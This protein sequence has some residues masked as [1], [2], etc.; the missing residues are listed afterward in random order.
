MMDFAPFATPD[1]AV[2]ILMRPGGKFVCCQRL[3]IL[4]LYCFQETDYGHTRMQRFVPD[5]NSSTTPFGTIWHI[6]TIG[7]D[8]I[9]HA[10]RLYCSR[11]AS[12][13]IPGCRHSIIAAVCGCDCL[14]EHFG[15][16]VA[17]CVRGNKHLTFWYNLWMLLRTCPG[18]TANASLDRTQ[19]GIKPTNGAEW[20]P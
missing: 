1:W 8:K 3:I 12:T 18:S 5:F 9:W 11:W 6:H 19:A 20:A 10:V 17:S 13:V 2:F 15:L 7:I 16:A 14:Q 4:M